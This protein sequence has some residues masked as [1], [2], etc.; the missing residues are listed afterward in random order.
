MLQWRAPQHVL[1]SIQS[2]AQQTDI[3]QETPYESGIMTI[4]NRMN[5][6]SET[7]DYD[8]VCLTFASCEVVQP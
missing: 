4:H 5:R 1:L 2:W 3:N 8:S 6:C 7:G